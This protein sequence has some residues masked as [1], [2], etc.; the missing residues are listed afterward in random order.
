MACDNHARVDEHSIP[1]NCLGGRGLYSEWEMDSHVA[2]YQR[3]G[4]RINALRTHVLGMQTPHDCP[5]RGRKGKEA[6]SS[7]FIPS[8]AWHNLLQ[9]CFLSHDLVRR[10]E[11]DG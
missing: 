8:C 1:N 11:S 3:A 7:P 5:S 6:F 4:V 9:G 2:G 10:M